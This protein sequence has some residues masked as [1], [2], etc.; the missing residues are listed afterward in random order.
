[1]QSVVTEALHS[2]HEQDTDYD[3]WEALSDSVPFHSGD[4]MY[5]PLLDRLYFVADFPLA[6]QKQ[7]LM[8][9]YQHI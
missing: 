2:I 6:L 8:A 5:A 4:K 1:M 3:R 9:S 7:L